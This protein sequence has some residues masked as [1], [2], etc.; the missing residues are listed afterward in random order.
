MDAPWKKGEWTSTWNN[1]SQIALCVCVCVCRCLLLFPPWLLNVPAAVCMY[2]PPGETQRLCS[3]LLICS[4]DCWT[5][6]LHRCFVRQTNPAGLWNIL[7]CFIHWLFSHLLMMRKSLSGK[8]LL[9]FLLS[10]LVLN[11][12]VRLLC[13]SCHWYM[14]WS[15]FTVTV[16]V[17]MNTDL[18]TCVTVNATCCTLRDYTGIANIISML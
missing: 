5:V 14:Q 6:A 17:L 16:L 9:L 8:M 3:L 10:G 1:V 12:V 7:L 2:S 11:C 4:L 13:Q 15:V 18:H